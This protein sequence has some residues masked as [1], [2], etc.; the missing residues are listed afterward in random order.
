M[1]SPANVGQPLAEQVAVITGA[2]RGIGAAI[3]RNL[4]GMGASTVL[5]G[6]T[7]AHLTETART[8]TDLGGKA[9]VVA[10]DVQQL[11]QLEHAAAR[12]E[13]TFGR[14]DILVNNAGIGGFKDLLHE[15]LP[16]DWD[17]IMN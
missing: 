7:A 2:G 13:S 9:E 5:L 17:K 4:A 12:V 14:C 3:A 16:E 15:T 1:K 11:H 8:I 10:C 6:R